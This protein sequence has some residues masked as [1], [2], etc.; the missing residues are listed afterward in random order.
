M[1][2][3]WHLELKL[4]DEFSRLT[5]KAESRR[6]FNTQNRRHKS[7]INRVCRGVFR[8]AGAH[9]NEGTEEEGSQM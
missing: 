2:E 9:K 7:I 8:R 1:E 6:F 4:M 5:G 3:Q